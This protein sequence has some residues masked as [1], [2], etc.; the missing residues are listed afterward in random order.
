MRRWD[1]WNTH[2]SSS[3]APAKKIWVDACRQAGFAPA[4]ALAE[5]GEDYVRIGGNEGDYGMIKKIK[6]CLGIA[7]SNNKKSKIR[8]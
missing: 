7:K 1:F 5:E 3:T 4:I 2:K 6:L 8:L